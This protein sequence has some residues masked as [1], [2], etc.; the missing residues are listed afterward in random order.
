MINLVSRRYWFFLLS[1]LVIIPGLISLAIPPGLRLSVDFL[2]GTQTELRFSGQ[3]VGEGVARPVSEGEL[4][5]VLARHE[6]G[7]AIIQSTGQGTWL[8]RTREIKPDSPLKQEVYADFRSEFGS[9]EEVSVLGLDPEVA[10]RVAQNSVYAVIIAAIG[11]LIYISIAFYKVPSPF[12]YGVSAVVALVHDAIV[13]LGLFSIL[14]RFLNIEVDLLFL[15]AVLTVIGFSVHDTIV[16]FDRIRENI[17]RYYGQSFMEIVNHS[18]IQTMGRSLT[19][20]LTVVLTML[21]LFLLGGITTKLFALAL[22]VGIISGTYSSIF[23]A[24]MLLVV[25]E[26]G[27]LGRF[28]RRLI[29]GRA[30]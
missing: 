29:P 10:R 11:I 8:V 7:D 12:R 16:V 14:G 2:G 22:L 20:S 17:G 3:P 5:A 4:R 26:N 23:N 6:L 1:A 9:F 21:A 19:T 30:S 25:W 15:T 27:E 13:V 24:S 28:F 18:L